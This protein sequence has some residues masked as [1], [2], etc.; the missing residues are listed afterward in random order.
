MERVVL[1]GILRATCVG[2]ESS[3]AHFAFHID[4]HGDIFLFRLASVCSVVR[5]ELSSTVTP[6]L[7]CPQCHP[8]SL[9]LSAEIQNWDLGMLV[10]CLLN[11]LA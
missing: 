11:L 6:F 9:T 10:F 5:L 4:L 8:T 1:I 7:E 3:E 2:V